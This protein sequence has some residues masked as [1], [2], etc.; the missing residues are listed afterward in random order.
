MNKLSFERR[1]EIVSSLLNTASMR[2]CERDKKYSMK[3]IERVLR[4]VGDASIDY[5]NNCIRDL[6]VRC[7]Q[8][9]E[10]HSFS[11]AKQKNLATMTTDPSEAG[12]LWTYLAIDADT[13]FILAYHLAGDRSIYAATTFLR[14]VN[15]TMRRDHRGLFP[16]KPT[17]VTDKMVSYQGAADTVFGDDIHQAF[18]V[19]RSDKEGPNGE[20]LPGGRHIRSEKFVIRGNPQRSDIQTS[21]IE[22][23]NANIRN[24]CRRYTRKTYCFS[25]RIDNHERH[26]ALVLM[27]LNF[28]WLPTK[29]RKH[30]RGDGS[31][32]ATAT[33]AIAIGATKTVWSIEDLVRMADEF[34][35]RRAEEAVARG[36][37]TSDEVE[38][39]MAPTHWVYW[40]K[41]HYLAK[42]HK[43][44]CKSC[45]H[46]QGKPNVATAKGVWLPFGSKEAALLGAAQCEPDR[47]EECKICLGSYSN[48]GNG[49]RGPRNLAAARPA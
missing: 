39:A 22:R 32:P 16:V 42:V 23:V 4:D 1:V 27:Y 45:N 5:M 17:L 38:S 48:S 11:E 6:N 3:T 21:Y 15:A 33:S 41:L 37:T 36:A 7:I 49:Y 46:G 20:K 10:I 47:F 40:S 2:G 28:C 34:V 43:A 9:D 35:A 29:P 8:A 30:N 25:K 18:V 44:E 24:F 13:R 31:P 14:R 26:L 19:K 12:N